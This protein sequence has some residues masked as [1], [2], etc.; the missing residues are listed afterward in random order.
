[1]FEGHNIR[2]S[3]WRFIAKITKN[4]SVMYQIVIDGVDSST[5]NEEDKLVGIFCLIDDDSYNT[6]L[7]NSHTRS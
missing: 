6:L 2:L 4:R 1:M 3:Y 7:Y 5:R